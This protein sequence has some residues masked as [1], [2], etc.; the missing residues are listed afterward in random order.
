MEKR[1]K[2]AVVIC[3]IILV[4]V[5]NIGIFYKISYNKKHINDNTIIVRI[6][7]TVAENHPIYQALELYKKELEEISNGKFEVRIYPNSAL[8]GDRQMV[9]SVILGYIQA[10]VP[11]SSVLAGFDNRFMVVDLPFVF[12]S[13]KAAV[14]TLNGELGNDLN[15]ILEDLGLHNMGWTSSGFR[16]I[17]T[18][19][20][21]I[22]SPDK[23]KGISIRTQE[24][25]IHVASFKAWGAA[26]TPMA[27]S[28]L[29]TAL[30]QG[31]VDAQE[32]PVFVIVS[33]R[34]F[35]VQDTLSLTG[36][37]FTAG[38]FT[39]N[40]EFYKS[41]KG[42]EKECFDIA[43][44]HF[45]TTLTRLVDEQEITNIKDAEKAGMKI[46]NITNEE[47]DLFIQKAAPVYKLF[48]D[49]Y[50]GSQELVDKAMLY[51][52]IQ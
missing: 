14:T 26:P 27:F 17:T 33:N 48:I 9:E 39:F 49:K 23:L 11:P 25:P 8:G 21:P 15:P 50:D 16:Y 12:K 43:G 45:V 29:F 24:N 22:T 5:A 1:K 35:E 18:N 19:G 42:K 30:Q 13:T 2:S 31:A 32:N 38:T 4:L 10:S 6:G 20:N 46:V 40:N 36:H 52:K 44:K 28:E 3:V 34:L 37:F 51:N 47:K 41:L 7:T